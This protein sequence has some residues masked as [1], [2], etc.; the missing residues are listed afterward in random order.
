MKLK[1]LNDLANPHFFSQEKKGYVMEEDLKQEAIN[2][3]KYRLKEIEGILKLKN[4]SEI[5]I[6]E[7]ETLEKTNWKNMRD[8][9]AIDSLVFFV[10][11]T[12]E[13]LK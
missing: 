9:G 10:N 7:W 4:I 6:T 1:T 13:D 2:H 5:G 8:M 3:V 11:I 12:M